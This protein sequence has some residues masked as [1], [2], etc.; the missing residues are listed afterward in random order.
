[1][2]PLAH[3]YTPVQSHQRSF[4]PGVRAS[5]LGGAYSALSD[6]PSGAYYNPAGL[7]FAKESSL[8]LSANAFARSS[9]TYEDAIHG[10]DFTENAQSLY[11][12][13][14]GGLNRFNSWA[15]GYS[16]CTLDSRESEQADRFKEI[17]DVAGNL[18]NYSRTHQEIQKALALGVSFAARLGNSASVG[19][20]QFAYY[21]AFSAATHQL[22]ELR[23]G[24]L[25]VTD[26]K[27]EGRNLGVFT[28]LGVMLR[29]DELAIGIAARIPQPLTDDATVHADVIYEPSGS[30][31]EPEIGK[32]DAASTFFE[33]MMPRSYHLGLAWDSQSIWTLSSE[34]IYHAATRSS[35]PES[36]A[37]ALKA[38]LNYSAGIEAK[39]GLVALRLG[40][41]SDFSLTEAP[42]VDKV[43]QPT[44]V[45]FQG[46]AG[47]LGFESRN[48]E[49]GLAL[50]KRVGSGKAQII[51][52]RTSIQNVRAESESL[53]LGG[54]YAF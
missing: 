34:V 8:S 29:W 21:R 13:F 40:V 20:S 16:Y 4:F 36:R 12:N 23:D 43:N 47:G 27:Y 3:A 45:D 9:M 25:L 1:M 52:G 32:S 48:Y 41:F 26:T 51:G 15:V 33:E 10:D 39:L 31:L 35:D 42:M 49:I 17:N 53:V 54:R 2:L 19:V 44:H 37:P 18:E 28:Q 22:A 11:P 38:T 50:T 5:S 7:V 14:A 24:G 46:L 6:D 30:T